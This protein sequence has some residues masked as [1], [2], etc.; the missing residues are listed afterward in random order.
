MTV[1]NNNTATI[2]ST[3]HE[4]DTMMKET[5]AQ[6]VTTMEQPAPIVNE[7]DFPEKPTRLQELMSTYRK[8][9]NLPAVAPTATMQSK[10]NPLANVK[11]SSEI[12]TKKFEDL[13]PEV[14]QKV[15]ARIEGIDY[16]KSADIQNFGSTKESPMT[17][18]AEIIISK[19][20]ASEVG[21][22]SDPMTD[23]V[24][25]LKSNNPKE[26][27][28]KVSVDPDK[29]LGFFSSFREMLSMRN[30]KKKMFK[31]LAEH[32][33]IK[34]NL[35]A[36]EVELEKQKMDLSKD[37]TTY[38][39][40]EDATKDQ[41]LEFELDCIALY[42]MREDAQEKLDALTKKDSLDIM[43]LNDAN[44]LQ[45]A[46]E[47]I[48][49][50]IYTIQTIRVATIQSIPQLRVLVYGDEIIC[51][52]IDEVSSLVIPLWTWQY[53]IAIGAL[54]QK[55]ALSIQKTIR[56]ITSKLLTGNAKMLHDNMIAAQNELY[57]AAVAIEDLAVVQEYIDDMVTKVN[58][59]RKEATMKCVDG[60]KTMQAIEQKNYDLMAQ[61]IDVTAAEVQS[62]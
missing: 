53:A 28:R 49:R 1:N 58:E 22:L 20:S 30:A 45:A 10:A 44:A 42:L 54:K 56:G 29:E 17:K 43:E 51:E 6:N 57:A 34:K 55:E 31:A 39:K 33:T 62:N 2:N 40:M 7:A 3:T 19:Y 50:R 5:I 25:T 61:T 21:E 12:K 24:A 13:S 26:I 36:I 38:Q 37:V 48:D 32:D 41:V 16:T 47:R 59:T 18:H 15:L 23:L 27:V 9:N 11:I 14:Q 8:E 60:M 4:E 35:K 52:K 46:I